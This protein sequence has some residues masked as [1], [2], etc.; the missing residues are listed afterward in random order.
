MNLLLKNF[1]TWSEYWNELEKFNIPNIH[2]KLLKQNN[3]LEL[4]LK[5]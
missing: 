1:D 5:M 4:F 2:K 3:I